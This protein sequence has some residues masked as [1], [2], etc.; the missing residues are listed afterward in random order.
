M[1][2][3]S[4]SKANAKVEPVQTSWDMLFPPDRRSIWEESRLTK[5]PQRR[6]WPDERR[7]VI[8]RKGE[9]KA[10]QNHETALSALEELLSTLPDTN[11]PTDSADAR[12]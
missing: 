8:G 9:A 11:L 6:P 12:V 10:R 4:I 2:P 3:A 5:E 1:P 7:P